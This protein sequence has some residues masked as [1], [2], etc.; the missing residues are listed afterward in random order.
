MLI[1]YLL[2][3]SFNRLLIHAKLVHFVTN[4]TNKV[5]FKRHLIGNDCFNME[6]LKLKTKRTDTSIAN[7][8]SIGSGL[9]TTEYT[10]LSYPS[11][12]WSGLFREKRSRLIHLNPFINRDTTEHWFPSGNR[13]TAGSQELCWRC[14]VWEPG[15]WR[16]TGIRF[17]APYATATVAW[18]GSW[19]NCTYNINTSLYL[20]KQIKIRYRLNLLL[21]LLQFVQKIYVYWFNKPNCYDRHGSCYYYNFAL[22]HYVW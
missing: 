9:K 17:H 19:G 4:I 2:L 6:Y 8:R 21:P 1:I 11:F 14:R 18:A 13:C 16:G 15:R 20:E 12:T 5:T 10:G 22:I 3:F 7:P